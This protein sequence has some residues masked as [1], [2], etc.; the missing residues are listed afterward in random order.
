MTLNESLESNWD[1]FTFFDCLLEHPVIQ[2]S[3][4]HSH[5]FFSTL[6]YGS[7]FKALVELVEDLKNSEYSS[8]KRK[9]SPG[10]L[11]IEE[12]VSLDYMRV[13]WTH[14]SSTVLCKLNHINTCEWEIHIFDGEGL[15]QKLF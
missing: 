5:I 12:S 1:K 6:Q 9:E 11:F 10:V 13:L 15:R 14:I 7:W 2:S 8:D 3:D 4:T